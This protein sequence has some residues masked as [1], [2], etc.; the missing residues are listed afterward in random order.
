V[1]SG[2]LFIVDSGQLFIVDSGQLFIVDSGHHLLVI[3]IVKPL[4]NGKFIFEITLG[5]VS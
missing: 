2:H 5:V 4:N 1:D 3:F